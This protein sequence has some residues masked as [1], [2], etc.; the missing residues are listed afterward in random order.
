MH[1]HIQQVGA[2]VLYVA[3]SAAEIDDWITRRKCVLLK[4]FCQTLKERQS[5]RVSS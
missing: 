1:Y 4:V 2:S 5:I 3:Q